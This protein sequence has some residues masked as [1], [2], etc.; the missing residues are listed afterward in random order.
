MLTHNEIKSIMA[1]KFKEENCYFA[2]NDIK[3]RLINSHIEIQIRDYDH[4]TFMLV[5]TKDDNNFVVAVFECWILIKSSKELVGYHDSSKDYPFEE[6]LI[7]L[8]YHIAQTF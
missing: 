8:A 2:E 5:P 3:V 6:A 1:K 4:I 7:E